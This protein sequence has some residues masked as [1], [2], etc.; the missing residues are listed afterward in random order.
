MSN[1][2]GLGSA[3]KKDEKKDMEE[4]SQGG[5]TSGTS[6][7]RPTGGGADP[8]ADLIRQARGN[9]GGPAPTQSIGT[10]QI[11]ANG[12]M[13]GD[14]GEFRETSDQKNQAFLDELKSGHVPKELEAEAIAKWGADVRKVG[15]SLVDKTSETFKVKFDFK[16]SVGQSLACPERGETGAPGDQLVCPRQR[17]V[18][19][20]ALPDR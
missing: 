1:I 14:E 11:Y 10:I 2:H 17:F 7:L 3:P 13:L 4:F 20:C 16:K 8:M 18:R 9:T 6:V 15:V 19:A 12:F 5:K